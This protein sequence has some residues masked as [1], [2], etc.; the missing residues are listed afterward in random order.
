VDGTLQYVLVP[1][2]DLY[3]VHA[4]LRLESYRLSR[5]GGIGNLERKKDLSL[6]DRQ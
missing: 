4:D 6:F 1:T 2:K 5:L 3:G